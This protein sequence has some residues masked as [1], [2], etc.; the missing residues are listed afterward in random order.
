V[1]AA[2]GGLGKRLSAAPATV[3]ALAPHQIRDAPRDR[4]IADPHHRA[5]LD[6]DGRAAAAGAAAGTRDQLDLEV[7]P[8]APLNDALHLEPLKADEAANVVLQPLFLLA[9]QFMTI[10]SL[11]GQRMSLPRP[12]TRSVSKTPVFHRRRHGPRLKASG[13]TALRATLLPAGQIMR[14]MSSTRS[15]R[16]VPPCNSC[17]S[18]LIHTTGRRETDSRLWEVELRCPDCE[19]RRA[20]YYTRSELEQLD[21]ELNRA[22]SEIET[23]L[24]RLEALHMEEWIGLFMHALDLDLIGPDDF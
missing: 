8:V 18:L 14:H 17:G 5:V 22:V 11:V 20:S 23:Q 1:P 6:V 19:R 16:P 4:Q 2:P 21:R 15:N 13:V 24:G 9:P 7:E 3:T 10:R 12:S